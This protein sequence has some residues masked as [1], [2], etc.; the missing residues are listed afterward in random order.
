MKG[1]AAEPV[2]LDALLLLGLLWSPFPGMDLSWADMRWY[3]LSPFFGAVLMNGMACGADGV[4]WPVPTFLTA[5]F[6]RVFSSQPLPEALDALGAEVA[7][8]TDA[9]ASAATSSVTIKASAVANLRRFTDSSPLGSNYFSPPP[10]T[11]M[12]QTSLPSS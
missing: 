11:A 2:A 5:W 9:A 10:Q 7:A 4:N 3:D 1:A 6:F 12:Q 8:F